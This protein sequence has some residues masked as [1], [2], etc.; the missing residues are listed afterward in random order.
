LQASGNLENITFDS[1]EKKFAERE[2]A[3]GKITAP[4][5]SKEVVC[6]AHGEKGH[7]QDSS[8]G[9]GGRGGRGRRN[10]RGRR[11]GIISNL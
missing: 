5:S 4:S 3:V 6:F 8:R 2:K 9:R 11:G 1:L 10:S 7:D